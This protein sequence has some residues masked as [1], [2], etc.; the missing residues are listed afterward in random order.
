M[1]VVKAGP[2]PQM[3]GVITL[4][5]WLPG[6][7]AQVA[8]ARAWGIPEL[9]FKKD[10]VSALWIDD[11][12]KVKT[13]N[14]PAKLTERTD[15]IAQQKQVKGRGDSVFF[16]NPL[17]VGFSAKHAKMV[18]EQ[19]FENGHM[20]YVHDKARLYRAG[21]DLDDFY[22]EHQRQVKA[23]QMRDYRSS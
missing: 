3:C 5:R 23:A 15:L 11:V 12:R 6:K 8:A 19:V 13:T 2:E 17:A 10:D 4:H 18:I 21:D 20:V 14:W 7:G 1:G 16:V 9:L 22:V